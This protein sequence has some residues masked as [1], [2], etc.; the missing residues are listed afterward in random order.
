MMKINPK[1]NYLSFLLHLW[2]E[3]EAGSWG[4]TLKNP[5]NG[6]C[7]GFPDFENLYAFLEGRTEAIGNKGDRK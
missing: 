1:R 7:Y 6:E 4:V 5:H 3:D 2:Q